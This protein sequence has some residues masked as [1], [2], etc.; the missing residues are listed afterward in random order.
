MENRN[1]IVETFKLELNPQ[2]AEILYG[3]L[4]DYQDSRVG[5]PRQRDLLLLQDPLF[6]LAE[7]LIEKINDLRDYS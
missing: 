4:Y 7:E 2:Q 5:S 1:P 3:I 6:N